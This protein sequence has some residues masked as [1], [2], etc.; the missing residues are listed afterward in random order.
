MLSRATT[1][2]RNSGRESCGHNVIVVA[3]ALPGLVLLRGHN[4]KGIVTT[5]QLSPA[6]VCCSHEAT[7]SYMIHYYCYHQYHFNT[8][9]SSIFPISCILHNTEKN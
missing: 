4:K 1:T 7:S 6:A 9:F 8:L 2:V 5:I 3:T